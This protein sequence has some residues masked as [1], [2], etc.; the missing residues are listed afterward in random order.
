MLPLN[1]TPIQ[2]EEP[3]QSFAAC[4]AMVLGLDYNEVSKID[5]SNKEAGLAVHAMTH[6]VYMKSKAITDRLE[7][8]KVYIAGLSDKGLRKAVVI[9]T[10]DGVRI[11]DPL[12]NLP[13]KVTSLA[14]VTDKMVMLVGMLDLG[15]PVAASQPR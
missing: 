14:D 4:Y 11:H 8:N 15:T 13:P 3:S 7:H 9:D 6:S 1:I 12:D 10:R 5:N 2:V